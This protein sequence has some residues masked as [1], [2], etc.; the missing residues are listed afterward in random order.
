M[1]KTLTRE[2]HKILN[3]A[4]ESHG[5]FGSQAPDF[6]T[7]NGI[8]NE[9]VDGK[10]IT[11]AI[12]DIANQ[13]GNALTEQIKTA[14][15]EMGVGHGATTVILEYAKTICEHIDKVK[16]ERKQAL[17]DLRSFRMAI[18]SEISQIEKAM[19]TFGK[20]NLNVAIDDII[21]LSDAIERPAIQGLIKGYKNEQA[22]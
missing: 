8:K 5:V 4:M 12:H 18:T 14:A 20:L 2:A 7:T 3:D 16:K 11:A 10:S 1:S 22:G 9:L 19:E 6:T 13:A 21:K 15:D 17:D